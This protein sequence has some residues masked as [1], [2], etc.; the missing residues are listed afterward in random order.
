MMFDDDSSLPG[1]YRIV[2]NSHIWRTF[3]IAKCHNIIIQ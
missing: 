3:I 2:Q 1:Q